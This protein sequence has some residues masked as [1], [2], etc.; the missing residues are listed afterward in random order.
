MQ[1]SERLTLE[2]E[3]Q[4]DPAKVREVVAGCWQDL[5][6]MPAQALPELVERAA[7]QRLLTMTMASRQCARRTS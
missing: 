5:R 6:G 3:E 4:V 2:F 7:R 1:A